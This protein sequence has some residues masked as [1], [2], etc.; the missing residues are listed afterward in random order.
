MTNLRRRLFEQL[1]PSAWKRAGLSPLNRWIAGAIVLSLA[2]AILDSEPEISSGRE[3]IFFALEFVFGI[4]FTVEYLA[5]LWASAE[6]P[7]HGRGLGGK[8][9]FMRSPAAV[10]DL[11]A[12][13]PMLFVF[14]GSEAYF[15]RL[16][17]LLRVLRLAKLG[18]LSDAWEHMGAAVSSR[19]YELI[20]SAAFA[21]LLMLISA[22]LLYLVEGQV[23]P[24]TFGSIPRAMW[25]SIC[26]LTTVGYGD[27][28]PVTAIG[29]VLAGIT[30]ITGIG[31]I[32]MPA[33]I[34]ASAFSDAIQRQREMDQ[35][36]DVHL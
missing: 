2:A 7:I 31:L 17:R 9:R 23:Q 3:N 29:K 22:T 28:Y 18:R 4:V 30:A 34:L 1:E 13:A 24:K 12:L 19:R 16:F 6:N 8:L 25:W 5:R 32:A 21:L 20:M 11:L 14:V 26:T 10:L 27:T 35:A 15:F 36:D 33:G